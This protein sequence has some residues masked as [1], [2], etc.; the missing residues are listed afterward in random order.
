MKL[1]FLNQLPAISNVVLNEHLV[2]F[3]LFYLRYF[4]SCFCLNGRQVEKDD[5]KNFHAPIRI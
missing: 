4:C 5:V 2:E 3:W 1:S